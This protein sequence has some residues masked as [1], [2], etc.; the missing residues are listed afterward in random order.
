LNPR[1]LLLLLV[2]SLS[3]FGLSV[4]AF[5][6]VPNSPYNVHHQNISPVI[7]KLLWT[8]PSGGGTPLGFTIDVA[9][10]GGAWSELVANTGIVTEYEISGLTAQTDY[11]F[12]VKAF[13]DEGPGQPSY[14]VFVMTGCEGACDYDDE[15]DF[16]EAGTFSGDLVLVER[17][18]PTTEWADVF[19]DLGLTSVSGEDDAFYPD[20]ALIY[21][22]FT[23]VT[24]GS[25]WNDV[26][27]SD[28]NGDGIIDCATAATCELPDLNQAVAYAGGSSAMFDYILEQDF[29][30]GQGFAENQSF[31]KGQD[32]SQQMDF[33]GGA[34]FGANTNFTAVQD[35]GENG[36]FSGDITIPT[37]TSA[38]TTEWADVF[39][40]MGITELAGKDNEGEAANYV[41]GILYQDFFPESKLTAGKDWHDIVFTDSPT[42]GTVGV[43]DCANA[44][45]CELADMAVAV[46]YDSGIQ[47][48]F[49]YVIPMDFS[50][51]NMVFAAGQTFPPG[52]IFTE[53]MDY[54]NGGMDFSEG[55]DFTTIQQFDTGG[56]FSGELT[57]PLRTVP[58]TEWADVFSDLG[59]QT[60]TGYGNDGETGKDYTSNKIIYADFP[61][62]V[63]SGNDWNDILFTDTN[64]NGKI[65]CP[66]ASACELADMEEAVTYAAGTIAVFDYV[67]EIEFGD[68]KGSTVAFG[69]PFGKGQSF[70]VPMDFSAGGVVFKTGTNFDVVQDFGEAGAFSADLDV[71]TTR[72][73]G[74]ATTE[75]ADVF[76]DMGVT[77][78]IG[79]SSDGSGVGLYETNK[80]I[81][82]D[83]SAVTAGNA[84]NDILF[85]DANSNSRIDCADAATCEL[86]DLAEATSYVDTATVSFDYV[87]HQDFSAG[88]MSFV[89]GQTFPKGQPI[90]YEMDFSDG[91]MIFEAG[92][93]FGEKQEFDESGTFSGNRTLPERT[94]PT[95]EWYDVFQDLGITSV[96]GYKSDLTTARDYETGEIIYADMS[97]VTAGEN[98]HDSTFTD[99]VVVNGDIDCT[100]YATCELSDM[101][102]AVTYAAGTTVW[103]D[104]FEQMTFGA[105]VE[106][107]PG[108]EFPPGYTFDQPMDFSKGGMV[109]DNGAIFT[110]MQNFDEA[111]A[112]S[113]DINI[114]TGTSAATTEWADVFE[115][116]GVTQVTG[117][118]ADDDQFDYATNKILYQDFIGGVTSGN[119]WNDV[120][121]TDINGNGL[122]D[123]ANASTCE[124]ADMETAVEYTAGTGTHFD[125]VIPMDFG[126]DLTFYPGQPFGAGQ[127][128]DQVMDFSNGGMEFGN[129]V[130]FQAIQDF[131]EAGTFS[132]NLDIDTTRLSGAATTEWAL[133]FDDM[134]VTEIEGKKANLTTDRDYT[135]GATIFADFTAVTTGSF[136]NDVV[137][138][139]GLEGTADGNIDCADAATCELSDL[140]QAVS[141]A[142]T[143]TIVFEQIDEM[144]FGAGIPFLPGQPFGKGQTFNE[145]VDFSAGAMIFNTGVEFNAIQNF[146][147]AG[148]FSGAKTLP[149]RTVATT[150]WADVFDDLSIDSVA[151][152]NEDGVTSSDYDT[153]EIIYADFTAVTA[154]SDWN[155]ILFTDANG[156]G[157]IDCASAGACELADMDVA[158]TYA[159]GTIVTFDYIEEQDFGAGIPFYPGQ[160]FGKGQTFDQPMDFSTGA[161]IF[162]TNTEFLAVQNFDEAGT[163]A[164]DDVLPLRTTATTEWADVF[165][166]LSIDSVAGFDADGVT[167][168]NYVTGIIFAD[169]SA[170]TAGV[171]Y[172]DILFTDSAVT[173]T[174]GDIDCATAATCEL[175]D[176]EVAVTYANLT[177]VTFD[178]IDSQDF[179]AGTEFYDGQDF[180][181]G[182]TFDE[183][184][185][186]SAGA[187]T[188]ADFVEFAPGQSFV[189]QDHDFNHDGMEFGSGAEFAA[190]EVFGDEID[191]SD[192]I[193]VFDGSNT[194]GDDAKFGASQ[195]FEISETADTIAM[196]AVGPTKEVYTILA[197]ADGG[198]VTSIAALNSGSFT[199][200]QKVFFDF[201][202]APTTGDQINDLLFT[203]GVVGDADGIIQCTGT[204]T[205]ELA[206]LEESITLAGTEILTVEQ[207]YVQDFSGT[208]VFGAGTEFGGLQDFDDVQ[209]FSAG[210]MT[211]APGMEFATNQDFDG[212][213]HDF[214]HD[215]IVFGAGAIFEADELFGDEADFSAGAVIFDGENVFGEDSKFGANQDFSALE[216][217]SGALGLEAITSTE[218]EFVDIFEAFDTTDT[219]IE[220]SDAELYETGMVQVEFSA[221]TGGSTVND[222]LFTDANSNGIIDCTS[223]AACELADLGTGVTFANT[224]TITFSQDLTQTFEGTNVFGAGTTISDN[225]D[226]SAIGLQDFTAGSMTFGTGVEFAAAED[227]SDYT[228]T[229]DDGTEFNGDTDFKTGQVFADDTIFNTGQTFDDSETMDFT[230]E[231]ITFGTDTSIDFGDNDMTFG[232]DATFA[233]GQDFT[234]GNDHVFTAT[235]LT[236]GAGTDFPTGG[237]KEAFGEDVN[238]TGHIDF[239]DDQAFP[240]GAEFSGSQVFDADHD[241]VF[242]D[243]STFGDGI[244]FAEALD[245][246][247]AGVFEGDAT[248]VGNNTFGEGTTF[249]DGVT[250]TGTQT[251][252]GA[253]DFGNADLSGATQ[254]IPAGSQ[255]SEGTTFADDQELAANTVLD[256]GLLLSGVTCPDA[257]CTVSDGD[258]LS[259]GEKIEPGVTVA[260]IS[261]TVTNDN[262]TMSIDGLGISLAFEEITDDGTID[263][264]IM[265][266]DDVLGLV[267]EV[268]DDG[269]MVLT[270]NEGEMNTVS[271]V[272]DFSYG[273]DAESSGEKTIVLPYNDGD[274]GDIPEGNLEVLH[275]V[276]DEWVVE[277]DC[278]VDSD[279]NEITCIVD[280]IE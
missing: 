241:P 231:G 261:N 207:D 140:T 263:V 29:T 91:A 251:F 190:A 53:A 177:V 125:Y 11:D 28:A 139:D 7:I 161:M 38:E 67:I 158:T 174:V 8:T 146:E 256:S 246:K 138:T 275:Y 216:T 44:S 130:E 114:P 100:G 153:G 27:F 104:Y 210:A 147:E 218:V 184:V 134:G 244:E 280:S 34:V 62:G 26:I 128:F 220:T 176:M 126:D 257:T 74:A 52:T 232:N 124:L 10:D 4:P 199:H 108:Q 253:V 149:V 214:V 239:P 202:I 21:A 272:I 264:Q 6:E 18:T 39:Q 237:D 144:D 194:F 183:E 111:G 71:D 13:N 215:E 50:A 262:P 167:P 245:F 277:T 197:A 66:V 150:E 155:D 273:G 163:F 271:S 31:G 118:D 12:K 189:G 221:V 3:I 151:G 59:I 255:F 15:Q 17:T 102:A 81:Y 75:W 226:F 191:F 79:F 101:T 185:D 30:A 119:D 110:A 156:D 142:N 229:F 162:D 250:F 222:V 168:S 103:F 196:G 186:F 268:E 203:D 64:G 141:Y 267:G 193:M 122:I 219:S 166:D 1:V 236:F 211:F 92:I 259:S 5:A 98:W 58:T 9:V 22:D 77:Q 159:A 157:I 70:N 143:A 247:D 87:I 37:G 20:N 233:D 172:N 89:E 206:D 25:N 200:N 213:D 63:T 43:I 88:N 195:D 95:T 60:V 73:V 198:A 112:F 33:S 235:N 80:I 105:D 96:S 23:A 224:A 85:T 133:V 180:G 121:F 249:E 2:I 84:F 188:F 48:H 208:N 265:D 225:Q 45:T 243:F 93:P 274:L 107:Y 116:M 182:Q 54:S 68:D 217:D 212:Q 258:V 109:F 135:S 76:D 136:W 55:G 223:D 36:A 132:G 123:C 252:S 56:A 178:Q 69:Q 171:E 170:V 145:T 270:T 19:S 204:G 279:N 181:K 90:N 65:D 46:E 248:F 254:T 148:T 83:F 97:S 57:L 120:L 16:D 238:F 165:D 278:T 187:M 173:G 209:D 51:G 47:T 113:G 234:D 266:P 260:A 14:P 131:D 179:G 192:G 106:F 127:T 175:A 32:F 205:C 24:S 164:V 137:F 228:H 61:S 72:L 35:F 129:G 94:A 78:V 242:D 117:Y 42:T 86:A 99:N 276:D 49:D 240:E 115:D 160:P 41:S 169:F 152:F 227:F 154:G 40:D 269:S 82:A 201:N 230:A